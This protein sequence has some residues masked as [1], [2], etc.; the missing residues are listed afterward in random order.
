MPR[1]KKLVLPRSRG[2]SGRRVVQRHQNAFDHWTKDAPVSRPVQ[3]T[4]KHQIA[5]HPWWTFITITPGFRLSVHTGS[6]YFDSGIYPDFPQP[7]FC[8]MVGAAVMPDV[9]SQPPCGS[10]FHALAYNLGNFSSAPWAAPKTDQGLVADELEGRSSSRSARRSS[11][12]AA[13]SPSRWPRVRHP[14]GKCSRRFLRLIAELRP[15]PP[16]APA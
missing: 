8:N 12:T 7:T 16:P 15:Q 3:S 1:I 5:S 2:R 10:S 6:Y 13:T 9:R 11:A 14:H 4:R